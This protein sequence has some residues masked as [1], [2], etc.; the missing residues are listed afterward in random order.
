MGLEILDS[1]AL[2]GMFW[3]RLTETAPPPW[4]DPITWHN[5]SANQ[6]KEEYTMLSDVPAMR[7]HVGGRDEK[8][9]QPF[10]VIVESKEY[11]ATLGF[12]RRDLRLDKTSQIEG[13]IGEL[14]VGARRIWPQLLT[15]LMVNGDNTVTLYGAKAT[16]DGANFFGNTHRASQNNTIDVAKAGTKPTSAEMEGAIFSALERAASFKDTE[17]QPANE[18]ANAWLVMVPTAL[19]GPAA[20]ALKLPLIQGTG[21]TRDNLL[22]N[23]G[24][25]AFQLAVN[26][27]LDADWGAGTL[28]FGVFRTDYPTKPLIRQTEEDITTDTLGETS[29]HYFK[30][31]R[32][33][34]GVQATLGVGYGMWEHALRVTFTGP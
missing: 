7:E 10:S 20:A 4:V 3:K 19:W 15:T 5:P 21:G 17:G 34:F 6:R 26:S 27:R 29:E 1:R 24:G 31:K 11:E 25:Q 14:A 32:V 8:T 9:L 22:V 30:T 33:L 23:L 13:R 18:G 12:W 2:N 28:R 16:V